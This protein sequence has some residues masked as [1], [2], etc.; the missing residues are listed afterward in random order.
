MQYLGI[1]VPP[2]SFDDWHDLVRALAQHAVDTFGLVEVSKWTFE[3]WNELW[4]IDNVHQYMSL[5]NASVL[6]VKSVAS[7]LIVGGPATA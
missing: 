6:A 7:N 2:T 4:G 1:T 5:Y 3:V